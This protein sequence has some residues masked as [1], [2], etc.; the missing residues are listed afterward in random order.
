VSRA[1][2]PVVA[3]DVG[4]E[5]PPSAQGYWSRARRRLLR[6]HL[7]VAGLVVIVLL[8]GAAVFAPLLAPHDPAAQDV[9]N[10]REGPS[11]Q[12]PA[13]TDSLG[14]DLLSRLIHGARVSLAV[15]VMAQLVVLGIGVPLGLVAGYMGRWADGPLMRFTD[16]VYAFPDLLLIILLRAV[17]G[18]NIFTLFL[19][20]GLVSWVDVARL[21]RGQALSLR[22][23]EFVTAA[24]ML[25]AS[26][27]EI[28]TRHLLPNLTGPLVVLVALG[29]PRAIFVE[30]ALSYI[31][32][33]VDPS[34][35]SWGSMV[36]EGQSALIGSA[37]HLV[38]FPAAAIALLTLAFTFVGDGLRDALD[39]H[40]E[41]ASPRFDASERSGGSRRAK[42]REELPRAA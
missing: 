26:S 10:A 13:G 29:I 15:G 20:I 8:A 30:A 32:F 1:V 38:M 2:A 23:R 22:E 28:M 18:G 3:L 35:P 17:I 27:R 4:F 39:P 19:I 40:A 12:H 21:V 42:T 14:R 34:V 5:A 11:W 7:A 9:L 33:G 24:R 31:G 36:Q 6:N 25:G 37:V 41:D 16:M